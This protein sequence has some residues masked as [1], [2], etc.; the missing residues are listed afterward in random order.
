MVSSKYS[1]VTVEDGS[2]V[3][4]YRTQD[5]ISFCETYLCNGDDDIPVVGLPVNKHNG[6]LGGEVHTNG[7]REV[8]VDPSDRCNDFDREN[9]VVLQH[10]DVVD[11]FMRP[12]KETITKNYHDKGLCK[13]DAEVTR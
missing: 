5:C 12:H 9:L 1:F 2:I 10:L 7:R 11:P 13:M 4:G 6:R 3:K 8:H